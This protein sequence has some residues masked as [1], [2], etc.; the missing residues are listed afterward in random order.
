MPRPLQIT[1]S[2]QVVTATV[3][4]PKAMNAVNFELMDRLEELIDQLSN[5]SQTRL[6]ILTGSDDSFISGGD[7]REFHQLK[8]ADE[9][10]QMTRRMLQLLDRIRQLPFWTMAVLNGATYGGGWEIAATFD[11]R[12]AKRGINI[13]F[14]QGKF[15][16][17]PGWGGVVSLTRLVPKQ[18]ALYWLA[19]QCVISAEKAHQAG[20]VDDL[21]DE[22]SYSDSLSEIIRNLTRNDRSFIE[23]LKKSANFDDPSH[24]VEPFSKF[25][26]SQ[27]HQN[28]VQA[29]LDRKK[30]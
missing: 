23:Y 4:R 10:R 12:V 30:S 1:H 14:T 7:L 22:D 19:N 3:N 28:R 21:I 18:K 9:A 5:D 13:G 8:T 11:F 29:F 27:E 25:W 20:F 15:Y 24:E 17:P 6:L 2:D 26:E 16:L